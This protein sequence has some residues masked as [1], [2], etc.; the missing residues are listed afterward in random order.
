MLVRRYRVLR[1]R[2][3]R[4]QVLL[5]RRRMLMVLRGSPRVGCSLGGRGLQSGRARR[6][7]LRLLLLLRLSVPLGLLVVLLLLDYR[8]LRRRTWGWLLLLLLLLNGRLQ[9]ILRRRCFLLLLLGLRLPGL[10][11]RGGV[12]HLLCL[13][14]GGR[15]GNHLLPGSGRRRPG[16]VLYLLLLV[17]RLRLVRGGSRGRRAGH[18]GGLLLKLLLLRGLVSVGGALRHRG[19]IHHLL[20]VL[21]GRRVLYRCRRRLL[22]VWLL[23]G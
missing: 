21:L 10:R 20:L 13:L 1:G 7:V 11:S 19:V 12:V 17:L 5:L 4:L 15:H 16:H 14:L 22:K 6:L 3:H 8:L 18:T 2:S 9:L 23:G